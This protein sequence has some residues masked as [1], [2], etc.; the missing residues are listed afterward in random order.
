[1]FDG[2]T[3]HF[4]N[5]EL[6]YLRFHLCR[7]DVRLLLDMFDK[8][9]I[10]VS[11]YNISEHQLRKDL[12]TITET[13]REHARIGQDFIRENRDILIQHGRIALLLRL[14]QNKNSHL[15]IAT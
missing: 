15:F 7:D 2:A 6:P 4:C 1:M 9:R 12:H 11:F 14:L 8:G 3:Q 10:G 5:F 13:R